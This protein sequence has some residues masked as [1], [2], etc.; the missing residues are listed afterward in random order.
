MKSSV[1]TLQIGQCNL[2]L[3]DHLV[4]RDD[5]IGVKESSMEDTKTDTSSDEFE[6]V[7][8]FRVDSRVGIDL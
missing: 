7:E 3:E 6:V 1:H 4:E 2:L 8:M 5:E